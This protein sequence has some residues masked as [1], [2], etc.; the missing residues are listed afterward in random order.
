MYTECKVKILEVEPSK[1]YD[2]RRNYWS[3]IYNKFNGKI[4][5]IDWAVFLTN[6]K[7]RLKEITESSWKM[8]LEECI[9]PGYQRNR[10]IFID[11]VYCKGHVW[12]HEA[13][14][15]NLTM[16]HKTLFI[17]SCKDSG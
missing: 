13:I 4:N 12:L 10:M 2:I 9:K 8:W 14:Y 16:L 15:T 17:F 7:L 1:E 3:D 6:S 11:Q 5:L